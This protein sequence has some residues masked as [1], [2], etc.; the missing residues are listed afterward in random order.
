MRFFPG[1]PLYIAVG[2]L[3]AID[4]AWVIAIGARIYVQ[5]ALPPIAASLAL[6]AG[7]V[8]LM[9]LRDPATGGIVRHG[10]TVVRPLVVERLI[11]GCQAFFF[12]YFAW[13]ALRIYN[14]VSMSVAFP[15]TDALL[16]GADRWLGLDWNAYFAFV[17]ENPPLIWVLEAAYTSLSA[18][19]AW[20]LMVLVFLGRTRESEYFAV[21][22]FA[23]AIICTTAGMFF[24]ANAAV[25]EILERPELVAAFPNPPGVYHLEFMAAL[26]SGDPIGLDLANLP[27]LVT[28]PSFHTAAGIVVAWCLRRTLFFWPGVVYC[29]VMIASTPVFG[30]HYFIDLMAGAVV[31]F[32]VLFG[33]ARLPRYAGLYSSLARSRADAPVV[34]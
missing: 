20:A 10:V 26:R 12:L 1:T 17:A 21:T 29:S 28:F 2:L 33:F 34:A 5:D 25:V 15:Y 23:T 8:V 16:N 18:L 24:P 3:A 9:R 4:V 30:G 6:L 22:F 31:A 13:T 19:S 32:A 7:A 27:G 11:F 14:H